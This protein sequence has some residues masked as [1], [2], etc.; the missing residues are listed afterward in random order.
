MLKSKMRLLGASALV[1]AG[2]LATGPV[3][4]ANL[5]LGDWNVQIDNTV[6]TGLS[7]MMKDADEQFLPI[8]NG[9]VADGSVYVG[10]P[11]VS[12]PTGQTTPG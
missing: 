9:G 10:A 4:A 1:G 2:L 5:Q 7:M 12:A 3:S 8:S 6:S 11:D